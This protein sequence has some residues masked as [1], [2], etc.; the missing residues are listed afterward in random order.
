TRAVS[1][2]QFARRWVHDSS[3]ASCTRRL[4]GLG[5]LK[6]LSEQFNF[7]EPLVGAGCWIRA[8]SFGRKLMWRIASVEDDEAVVSMSVA[9]YIEDPGSIVVAPNQVRRTLT[10]LRQDSGRGRALLGALDSRAVGSGLLISFWSNELGGEI[11]VIDE[12]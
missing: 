8:L 5:V 3:L 12:L 11:C 10:K 4:A 1:K 7:R 6:A 2:P 9:L